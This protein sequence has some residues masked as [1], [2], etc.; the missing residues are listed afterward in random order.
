MASRKDKGQE[1]GSVFPLSTPDPDQRLCPFNK[2]FVF[3]SE[4]NLEPGSFGALAKP[5]RQ[6]PIPQVRREEVISPW[7]RANSTD[8]YFQGTYCTPGAGDAA[9]NKT[10]ACPPDAPILT[11]VNHTFHQKDSTVA[12][13]QGVKGIR[14]RDCHFRREGGGARGEASPAAGRRGSVPPDLNGPQ[15]QFLQ[16]LLTKHPLRTGPTLSTC[17]VSPP[18]LSPAARPGGPG[19]A[20]SPALPCNIPGGLGEISAPLGPRGFISNP[21]Q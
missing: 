5:G 8:V 13:A 18:C 4:N 19:S 10:G 1:S 2:H 16:H 6:H 20:G 17:L 9:E 15:G 14:R 21:A 12:T 3:P 7:P 11:P